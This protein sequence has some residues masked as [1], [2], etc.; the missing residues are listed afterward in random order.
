MKRYWPQEEEFIVD[1][2]IDAIETLLDK[3]KKVGFQAEGE[4]WLVLNITL[5]SIVN[6]EK[7]EAGAQPI[8]FQPPLMRQHIKPT[9]DFYGML[10]WICMGKC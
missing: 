4:E 3:Q 2:N 9:V 1:L 5:Y 10:N 6:L 8:W 7:R